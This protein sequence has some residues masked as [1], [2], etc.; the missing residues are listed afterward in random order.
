MMAIIMT[1][2][3][4]GQ[5][6]GGEKHGGRGCGDCDVGYCGDVVVQVMEGGAR[7]V[8]VIIVAVII[9]DGTG[10]EEWVRTL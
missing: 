7:M 4:M 10:K 1:V 9:G 5:G 8:V 6:K 3:M 2:I